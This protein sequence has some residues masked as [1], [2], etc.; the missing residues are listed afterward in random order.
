MVVGLQLFDITQPPLVF[1]C[2]RVMCWCVCVCASVYFS[3]QLCAFLYFSCFFFSLLQDFACK[4]CFVLFCVIFD[5]TRFFVSVL[6]YAVVVCYRRIEA[7]VELSARLSSYLSVSVT[8][9]LDLNFL[10]TLFTYGDNSS[11]GAN[12]FVHLRNEAS[13]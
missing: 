6:L 11:H 7:A 3:S 1:A 4:T 12:G 8:S 2:S 9:N 10:A 13:A 5:H